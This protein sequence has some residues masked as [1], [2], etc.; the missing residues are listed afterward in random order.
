MERERYSSICQTCHLLVSVVTLEAIN[1]DK[2]DASSFT[3]NKKF[4]HTLPAKEIECFLHLFI[5]H[6]TISS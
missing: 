1:D 6:T 4:R 2:K 3:Y 5:V